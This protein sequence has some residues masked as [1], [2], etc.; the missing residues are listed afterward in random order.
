MG[1]FK[2][3]CTKNSGSLT[4][5]C[6]ADSLSH[7]TYVETNNNLDTCAIFKPVTHA[8]WSEVADLRKWSN[9]P[10]H[11]K[12][13]LHKRFP[14]KTNRPQNYFTAVTMLLSFLPQIKSIVDPVVLTESTVHSVMKVLDKEMKLGLTKH[15]ADRKQT[16]LQMENTYVRYL[17]DGSGTK[18][19]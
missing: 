16:S 7:T 1:A 17:L 15:E 9:K 19:S 5:S 14:T 11:I 12:T 13:R 4:Y 8:E 2:E 3:F 10:T 6:I 18:L